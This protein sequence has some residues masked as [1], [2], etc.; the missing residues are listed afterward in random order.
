MTAGRRG[1]GPE[2]RRRIRRSLI[3]GSPGTTE[4]PA[5]VE[6]RG[7]QPRGLP[8][9]HKHKEGQPPEDHGASHDADGADPNPHTG[10]DTNP[11][12]VTHSQVGAPSG[13][14]HGVTAAEAGAVENAVGVPSMRRN[15]RANQ[16][17]PGNVAIGSRY[18]VRDENEVEEVAADT[19]GDGAADS[20]VPVRDA[21]AVRRKGDTMTGRLTM[22]VSDDG[23]NHATTGALVH[24]GESTNLYLNLYGG[25]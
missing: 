4:S 1:E 19:T 21:G 16:P 11:H 7:R 24:F 8:R 2:R 13:N 15:T 10:S 9:G 25:D 6:P 14:P 22:D 12:S 18:T 23:F 20:W 5:P 3:P 17:S